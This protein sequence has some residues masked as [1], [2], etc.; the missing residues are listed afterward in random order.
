[1]FVSSHLMSEM[2]LIAEHYVIV[3]RGRLIADVTAA[4]LAAMGSRRTVRVRTPDAEVLRRALA[5]DGV[6]VTDDGTERDVLHVE[7]LPV[8]AIGHAALREAVELHEL[9]PQQGSLEQTFMELT[10]NAVEYSARPNP[11]TTPDRRVDGGDPTRK[12][13]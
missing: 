11:H 10:A 7:G 12:V 1:V 2:S 9:T 5:A 6:V 3:G 4:E 13:A 8:E